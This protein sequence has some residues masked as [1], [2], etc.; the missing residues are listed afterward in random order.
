MQT[1][2][3][4]LQLATWLLLTAYSSG[5]QPG[6]KLPP[7]GN[8]AIF[9]GNEDREKKKN[10]SWQRHFLS[11]KKIIFISNP[12]NDLQTSHIITLTPSK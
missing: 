5:S 8:E 6:G 11:L 4:Q 3:K 7:G 2:A 12:H 10:H 1:A 9:G